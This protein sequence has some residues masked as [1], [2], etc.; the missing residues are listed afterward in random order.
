MGVEKASDSSFQFV[1]GVSLDPT[2]LPPCLAC[3]PSPRSRQ[4]S[5]LRFTRNSGQKLLARRVRNGSRTISERS[6]DQD[7][8]LNES[9]TRVRNASTFP[10]STLMSILVT[11]ATRRSRSEPAAVSTARRPASSHDCSLTPTTSTIRYT[12]SACFVVIGLILSRLNGTR[13]IK[14]DARLHRGL[15]QDTSIERLRG[16]PVRRR[17]LIGSASLIRRTHDRPQPASRRFSVV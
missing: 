12:L 14:I 9:A 7:S 16:G 3:P 5:T 17:T 4:D 8:Y 6:S 1:E 2:P 13:T 11:S 10:F 15:Y